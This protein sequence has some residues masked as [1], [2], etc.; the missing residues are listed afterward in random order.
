MAGLLT[1]PPLHRWRV[2]DTV[3]PWKKKGGWRELNWEMSEPDAAEWARK[4]F[5][6]WFEKI[7]GSEKRYEDLDGR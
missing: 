1:S 4:N 2:Y 5:I 6:D 7:P 3:S